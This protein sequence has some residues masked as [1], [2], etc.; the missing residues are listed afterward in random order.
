MLSRYP[1]RQAHD[2]ER[3]QALVQVDEVIKAGGKRAQELVEQRKLIN[4]ELE[5]YRND[6]GKAPPPLKR[7]LEENEG[8]VASQKR[9]IADQD[10]EKKRINARFDAELVKLKQLWASMGVPAGITAASSP[11]GVA[12]N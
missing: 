6:P 5:F 4:S 7:R 9:F 8:N 12:K 11:K 3:A 1:N 2:N 10:M